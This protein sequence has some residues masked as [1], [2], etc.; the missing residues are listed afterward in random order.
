MLLAGVVM[1]LGAYGCLR[2]AMVLFPDGVRMWQNEIAA[3]AVIGIIYGAGAALVQ[4]DFKFVIG[5]SSVSHMG[6]VLLGLA[7]LNTIGLSGAVLQMFSHGI[8]AGLLFAVV[9]RMVYDRTHTRDFKDLQTMQLGRLLPFAGVTF[10]LAGVASMGLPGFSGFVAELQVLMGAWKVF[11]VATILSGLGIIIG[12]AY[13]L[14]AVQKAFYSDA[15]PGESGHD[16]PLE[17]ISVPERIGAVMLIAASLVIGLF[18]GLLLNW[19]QPCL[20][21]PLSMFARLLN[22]GGL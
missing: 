19:I 11:P 10:V 16:H 1:K 21:S 14:R 9:G 20:N 12:V 15:G 17:P 6:F 13:I 5:Y 22:G 3:L 18:P 8:I 2:V 4:K 7:T